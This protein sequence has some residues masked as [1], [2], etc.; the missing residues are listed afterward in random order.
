[1]FVS[2]F[3]DLFE[4]VLGYD[5]VR[6]RI[7]QMA[8]RGTPQRDALLQAMRDSVLDSVGALQ[9]ELV[10]SKPQ[11]EGIVD[12][13]QGLAFDYMQRQAPDYKEILELEKQAT[14][15]AIQMAAE[16]D[17][18]RRSIPLAQAKEDLSDDEIGQ[19]WFNRLTRGRREQLPSRRMQI[20]YEQMLLD[21]QKYRRRVAGVATRRKQIEL[22]LQAQLDRDPRFRE[23]LESMLSEAGPVIRDEIIL[24]HVVEFL[25]GAKA[26]QALNYIPDEDEDEDE[27]EETEMDAP[28]AGNSG[29]EY[30]HIRIY[31][32]DI[33]DPE[34]ELDLDEEALKRRFLYPL[35]RRQPVR[36]NGRVIENQDM[37][38]AMISRSVAPARELLERIQ[39]ENA[40]RRVP[41]F[42]RQRLDCQVAERAQDMTPLFLPTVPP[43]ADRRSVF[44][45][46][47]RW[48]AAAEAMKDF[49]GA[50]DLHVIDWDGARLSGLEGQHNADILETAFSRAYAVV[51]LMT[52]DDVATLHP[53][54]GD[55]GRAG[56][57][58]QPRPNVLFE[59][60]YAW[61][62]NR[63]RTLIVEFGGDLRK[64]S[65]LSGVD[66]V[67]FDGSA[68][69]RNEVAERLRRIPLPVKTE[70]G[71]YLRKGNFPAPLRPVD[72]RD[73]GWSPA[74]HPLKGIPLHWVLLASLNSV[75]G[76]DIETTAAQAG[77]RPQEVSRV[78]TWL[79]EE[80]LVDPGRGHSRDQAA[81]NGACRLTSAG[82]QRLDDEIRRSQG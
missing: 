32:H 75:H 48:N 40:D 39:L 46:R 80:G 58:G 41:V 65:N 60:G 16:S 78:L 20:E 76:V 61:H 34:V 70:N 31:V 43:P 10:K 55:D 2:P 53:L 24:P 72:A 42:D 63:E 9:G 36:I 29:Q 19:S 11:H 49:L 3:S 15:R 5:D 4:E 51:V 21:L 56:L 67:Q 38:R 35:R 71:E 33:A 1:M 64:L 81:A 77:I 44:L 25:E 26:L 57:V 6:A 13:L 52:P 74:G 23:Q 68:H 7:D 62:A 79:M 73:L 66:R 47:G 30:F 37:E 28:D 8:P 54:L 50:L 18:F 59:A 45:V 17:D 14:D 22:Q 69:S 12:S 27:D 82:L